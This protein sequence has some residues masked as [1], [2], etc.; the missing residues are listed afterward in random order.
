M[1][2]WDGAG[3]ERLMRSEKNALFK[4]CTA[5]LLELKFRILN[6]ICNIIIQGKGS[7]ELTQLT[8]GKTI[9]LGF[10]QADQQ[11]IALKFATINSIPQSKYYAPCHYRSD[12]EELSCFYP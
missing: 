5:Y 2:D 11:A 4:Y 8:P 6:S 10:C 7:S 12:R 3:E 1:A 9:L